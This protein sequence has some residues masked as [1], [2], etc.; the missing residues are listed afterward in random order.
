MQE[1][2]KQVRQLLL[3]ANKTW[4]YFSSSLERLLFK[5]TSTYKDKEFILFCKKRLKEIK[6]FLVNIENLIGPAET[7]LPKLLE[8]NIYKRLEIII[9]Q[10]LKMAIELDDIYLK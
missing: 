4:N 10:M 8:K 1:K 9:D 6:A 7:I 3:Q 2:E 5:Q